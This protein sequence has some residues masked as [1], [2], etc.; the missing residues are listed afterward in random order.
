M[1]I[2][3]AAPGDRAA[4]GGSLDGEDQRLVDFHAV[5]ARVL[6]PVQGLV[7]QLDQRGRNRA[8]QLAKRRS[9]T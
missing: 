6:G 3:T 1:V 2:A 4:I 7:G 9:C 8:V 5:A